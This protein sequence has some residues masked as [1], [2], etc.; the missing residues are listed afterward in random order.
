MGGTRMAMYALLLLLVL[1]A[2]DWGFQ[3]TERGAT[4]DASVVYCLLPAHRDS[5]V[6]A[7]VSLGLARAAPVPGQVRVGRRQLTLD[8]W[9][10]ADNDGFERACDALAAS[11]LPPATGGESAG[12]TGLLAV[13]VPVIAGALLT[14]AADDFRQASDRRWAQADELRA[15]WLAFH[16]AVLAYAGRRAVAPSSGIPPPAE[17]DE[18]R[19]DLTATLRKVHS[20]RRRW[21]VIRDLQDKLAT[22]SLGPKIADGWTPGDDLNSAQERSIRTVDIRGDLDGA[23]ASVDGIASALERRIWLSSRR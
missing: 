6:S 23:R 18:R 3:A 14:M 8:A 10:R 1:V 9:R 19:R 13:L 7:A 12:A 20:Q 2:V 21:S 4:T 22:G 5:L 11:S 17:V 16:G 15:S